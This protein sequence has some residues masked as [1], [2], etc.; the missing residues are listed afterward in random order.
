[1]ADKNKN[2]QKRHENPDFWPLPLSRT[3][4]LIEIYYEELNTS[5]ELVGGKVFNTPKAKIRAMSPTIPED[6]K[7]Q[8]L[9]NGQGSLGVDILFSSDNARYL[10]EPEYEVCGFE[11]PKP[12][13]NNLGDLAFINYDRIIA[14]VPKKKQKGD[15][16]PF[17]PLG[18][19]VFFEFD[20]DD[21]SLA[22]VT[23]DSGIIVQ[24]KALAAENQIATITG[25]GP[26]CEHLKV[27]D[28]VI[29]RRTHNGLS[30]EGKDYFFASSE[31][32]I[33]AKLE[34]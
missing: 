30:F 22:E 17:K 29:A 4:A 14:L 5:L 20:L 19:R 13:E 7:K 11:Y 15:M 32:E 34:A 6:I 12:G 23:T 21:E 2:K 24:E 8:M 18:P 3:G 25:V 10:L 9:P 27:G 31:H 26:L 16:L 33:L 28:R 1:M